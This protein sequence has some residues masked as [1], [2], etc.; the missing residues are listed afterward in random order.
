MVSGSMLASAAPLAGVPKSR[1]KILMFPLSSVLAHVG[2][3]VEI[4]KALRARG[5]ETV[6]AGS[7]PGHRGSHLH[8][9]VSAGFRTVRVL[10]P[11]WQWAWRRFH[12][13][14]APAGVWDFLTHQKWAPLD[15]ILEDMIRVVEAEQPD[16]LLGDASI[17][18]STVGHILGLPAAGVLNSYN[19]QF[20][21]PHSLYRGL[22]RAC[23]RLKWAPIRAR[24]YRRFG[25]TPVNAIELLEQIPLLS[26]DLAA[27]HDPRDTYPNWR[28]I[29][30][31]V[32]ETPTPL[33][34]WYDELDD[35][36]TN[37]YIT[38]GSTGLLEPLLRRCYETLAHSPYR[39]VVTTGG[40]VS[41][42]T[43]ACAPANFRFAYHAPGSAILRSSAAMV[44][45]GGNGSMYQA[46]AA[47]VPM[48]ALPS[49]LEQHASI[50]AGLREG[51]A[52]CHSARHI[53]GRQLLR[54]I[55]TLMSENSYHAN[56]W[57][58]QEPVR[59]A[60]AAKTAA[61]FLEGYAG[62]RKEQC[63]GLQ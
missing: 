18:V 47:G 28:P 3:T 30:P 1:L 56:A 40:Q 51:F 14:G 46:L 38:M 52:R 8:Y 25:V 7:D 53:S 36:T 32:F 19:L 10:E 22:I 21:R 62:A 37:V 42:A 5:H 27:F 20:F 16:L 33:P 58:Y 29:G 60:N 15:A 63:A 54:E 35:G 59:N 12:D 17:G 43:I 44:F 49:H 57:R 9:A 39:F 23:N 61:A 26:P 6:F 41:D 48:L 2:R 55:E 13:H 24:V 34:D 4:A 11:D 45:H 31:L 50:A